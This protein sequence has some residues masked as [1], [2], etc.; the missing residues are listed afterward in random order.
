MR[1]LALLGEPGWASAAKLADSVHGQCGKA[2]PFP[3]SETDLV[4]VF[5][6]RTVPFLHWAF[7]H[8]GIAPGWLRIGA[9]NEMV[10]DPDVDAKK[11]FLESLQTETDSKVAEAMAYRLHTNLDLDE[12]DVPALVAATWAQRD[13]V[14][15]LALLDELQRLG[16]DSAILALAEFAVSS[17]EPFAREAAWHYRRCRPPVE[18]IL[19][20]L[21]LESVDGDT[22]LANDIVISC[23]GA[24]VGDVALFESLVKTASADLPRT[25][26]VERAGRMIDIV[27]KERPR[28]VIIGEKVKP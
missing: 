10:S 2:G 24:A 6:G 1:S 13:G 9:V 11:V 26:R 7:A 19:V 25:F 8:P 28:G 18:G 14:A 12:K 3:F 21:S 22:L 23:D 17:D 27:L 16:T 20:R 4:R 5:S 15:V